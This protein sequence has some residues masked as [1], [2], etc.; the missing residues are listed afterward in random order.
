MEIT[1]YLV[2]FL[3]IH[4][5]CVGKTLAL[6]LPSTEFSPHYKLTVI[7]RRA[8]PRRSPPP[9][10]KLNTRPHQKPPFRTPPPPPPLQYSHRH[11]DA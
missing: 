6:E 1:S 5:M 8:V 10:P 9:P 2:I 11:A 3:L 7:T 4:G